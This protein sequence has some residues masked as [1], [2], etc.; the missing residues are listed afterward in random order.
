MGLYIGDLVSGGILI[1]VDVRQFVA[2]FSFSVCVFLIRM[3]SER[4]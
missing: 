4:E 2:G 1:G 3:V